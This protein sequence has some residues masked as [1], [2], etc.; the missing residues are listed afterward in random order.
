MPTL[1][2]QIRVSAVPAAAKASKETFQTNH[3]LDEHRNA[4]LALAEL[5]SP[6][7]TN[8][9]TATYTGEGRDETIIADTTANAITVTLPLAAEEPGRVYEVKLIRPG[10]N[11]LT[12]A[13]SGSD[14]LDGA[15]TIVLNTTLQSRILRSDGN[16]RWHV[17]G[18]YL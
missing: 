2:E 6:L 3:E 10:A 5:A 4:L 14:T 9:I 13:A 7:V 1:R 18:G 16:V 15:A 11:N 17:V 8:V 12:I